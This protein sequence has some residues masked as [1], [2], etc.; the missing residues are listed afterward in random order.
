METLNALRIKP[1]NILTARHLLATRYQFP[2]ESTDMYLQV[3]NQL[4]RESEYKA[5]DTKTNGNYSIRDAFI[6]GI[7][8]A[9]IR[10][11]LLEN[12]TFSLDEAYNKVLSMEIAE[13]YSQNFNVLAFNVISHERESLTS[14]NKK[15]A[16]SHEEINSTYT[17]ITSNKTDKRYR[18]KCF[19]YGG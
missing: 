1:K 16:N 3:I 4:A 17:A 18:R 15:E 5:V 9:K 11:H 7:I 14:K 10:E 12:L 6:A 13:N 2:Y 8:F 19:L